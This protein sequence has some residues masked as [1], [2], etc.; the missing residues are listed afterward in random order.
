MKSPIEPIAFLDRDGTLI[1]T[2]T[3]G[4]V[5]AAINDVARMSLLPGV[6]EGC[7]RLKENGF[8][9]VMVTNQP[10]VARGLVGQTEVEEINESL[11]RLLSL[12]LVLACFHDDMHNC[13]CRKPEPGML[14]EGFARLGGDPGPSSVILGDRWKDVEAGR[15]AGIST[16][17]LDGCYFERRECFPSFRC[18]DFED[19][20]TWAIENR[21]SRF[22]K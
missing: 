21:E 1:Y 2:E 10:D 18:S 4:D 22:G 14:L 12:D 9:L 17:L 6:P 8:R 11:K 13:D 20:V 3:R 19:G 15:R 5:P 7:R 16:V